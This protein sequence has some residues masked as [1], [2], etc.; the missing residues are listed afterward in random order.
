[1]PTQT[2][3]VADRPRGETW[4]NRSAEDVLSHLG[5]SV[6][7][8]FAE[9]AA[10]RLVAN[11]LNELTE[12]KR[13]SPLQIFLGQFRSLIIWLLIAA[14]VVSGVLGDRVDTSSPPS[15]ANRRR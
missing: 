3:H 14:G 9:E 4:H 7:G 11:G 15:P 1:M 2:P 12:G 6:H 10:K 5:S 8:L 13:I